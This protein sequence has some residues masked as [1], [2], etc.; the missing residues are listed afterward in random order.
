MFHGVY[1]DEKATQISKPRETTTGIA[2]VV[3]LAPIHK[4]ADP[5]KA[6]NEPILIKTFTEAK[7]KLGYS[8][9]FDKFT[10]C[11]SMYMNLSV[12]KVAPIIFVNVLDPAKVTHTKTVAATA[13]T[14]TDGQ[15]T[16]AE[17]YM[18]IDENLVVKN[19]DD[20]LVKDT[21]Y[22]VEHDEND[23]LVVTILTGTYASV[24]VAGKALN[25]AGVTASDIIGGVNLSTGVITGLSLINKVYPNF[26]INA[27]TIIAPGYSKNPTV[28]AAMA[29]LTEGING[30]F[31]AECI[32]DIDSTTYTKPTDAAAMKAAVGVKDPHAY[33]VWPC[34]KIGSH[35]IAGS[36]NAAAVFQYVDYERG[37]G[38]P[39]VPV[40]NK[41][42]YVDSVVLEDGTEIILTPEEGNILNDKG[43]A[44]Y[45]KAEGIKLWGCESSAYPD[46]N[47]PK[48]RWWNI[49]RFFT[50]HGN[51][52]IRTYFSKV[53]E[54]INKKLVESIIDAENIV[55]N[56]YVSAGACLAASI[57]VS[58]QNTVETLADGKLYFEQMITPPAPAQE[59]RNT[60]S[61]DPDALTEA[62]S[63]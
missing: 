17:K 4:L 49:R 6:V 1:V 55:M 13:V 5:S 12:R 39:Y 33:L 61:F 14:I 43:I 44:T 51:N 50:W 40:S 57:K 54:P 29:S 28:A 8:E 20:V 31:R 63:V 47:D 41:S 11:Q 46:T 21:D 58:D 34:V 45:V 19:G 52:F 38:M 42:A 10:L 22:A 27:A 53:D 3:G 24:T 16:L 48:D 26:G 25:P 62:L 9:E 18:L 36:A 7:D 60:L 2:F 23:N 59:I 15:G 37:A 30:V 35:I 32:I 56:G